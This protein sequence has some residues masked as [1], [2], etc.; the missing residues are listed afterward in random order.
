MRA[1]LVHLELQAWG[2]TNIIM[3]VYTVYDMRLTSR[4]TGN[5][6]ALVSIE[7]MTDVTIEPLN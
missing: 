4:L 6:T 1:Y 5:Y 3:F 7:T 2:A